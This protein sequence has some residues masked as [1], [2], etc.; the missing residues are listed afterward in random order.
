MRHNQLAPLIDAVDAVDAVAMH[1][2]MPTASSWANVSSL[3]R[4]ET[5]DEELRRALHNV[6]PALW[7]LVGEAVREQPA[8]KPRIYRRVAHALLMLSTWHAWRVLPRVSPA[9]RYSLMNC[10]LRQLIRT[11]AD[12]HSVLNHEQQ[13]T[14]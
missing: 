11:V 4:P 6:V 5:K 1:P 7:G 12:C 10:F 14:A 13:P 8:A 3:L 9:R 2:A